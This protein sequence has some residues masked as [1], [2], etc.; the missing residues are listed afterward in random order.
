M[1]ARTATKTWASIFVYLGE[2][3][4]NKKNTED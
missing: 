3:Y 1:R 2:R 4:E